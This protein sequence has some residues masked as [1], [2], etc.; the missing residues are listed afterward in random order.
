MSQK[1]RAL[2]ALGVA[3]VAAVYVLVTPWFYPAYVS[4]FDQLWLAARAWVNNEN[5]YTVVKQYWEGHGQPYG[6]LYPGTAIV[7]VLPLAWLPL[8]AARAVF[9]AITAGVFTYAL[10]GRGWWLYP[11]LLSASMRASVSSAQ[12]APLIAASVFVPLFGFTAAFKP[13]TAIPALF[14]QPSYSNALRFLLAALIAVTLSFV[15]YPTWVPEW[16]AAIRDGGGAVRP[17]V[18]QPGGFLLLLAAVRWREPEARWLLVFALTP[19]NPKVYDALPLLV[20]LP[21]N[22]RQALMLALL[23][24][25]AEL[26]GY[27]FQGGQSD[28]V[29]VSD[30]HAKAVLYLLYIPAL[31]WML[32][33]KPCVTP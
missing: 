22:H 2:I 28:W 24:H 3:A 4:D 15:I 1:R 18:M 13:N 9:V 20:L 11:V 14:A 32:W 33:R 31:G 21:K 30:I 26:M 10:L 7:L 27:A 8:E 19:V 25:V 5:P 23:S 6:L 16:L 17:L 29:H 12:I